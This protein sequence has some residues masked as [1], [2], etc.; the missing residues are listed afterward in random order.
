MHKFVDQRVVNSTGRSRGKQNVPWILASDVT[1]LVSVGLV[2]SRIMSTSWI[3]VSAW[4]YA[5]I[6]LETEGLT[7]HQ[8]QLL[9]SWRIYWPSWSKYHFITTL[10]LIGM[11]PSV[12]LAPMLAGAV[13]WKDHQWIMPPKQVS[14]HNTAARGMDQWYWFIY[15]STLFTRKGYVYRAAGFATLA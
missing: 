15:D 7:L 1:T 12:F 8:F 13:G 11:I 9:T 6:L 3:V 5:Y 10:G 4:R 2:V 14:Y